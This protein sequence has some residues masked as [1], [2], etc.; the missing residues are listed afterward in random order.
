MSVPRGV[1]VSLPSAS[2][3]SVGGPTVLASPV[4]AYA[5]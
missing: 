5:G 2:T 4:E 1:V 3:G